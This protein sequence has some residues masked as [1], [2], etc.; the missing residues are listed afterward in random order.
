MLIGDDH[1][2]D[3]WYL[4]VVKDF[5]SFANFFSLSIKLLLAVSISLSPSN[6]PDDNIHAKLFSR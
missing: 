5:T 6:I 3:A 2:V 1:D 4:A